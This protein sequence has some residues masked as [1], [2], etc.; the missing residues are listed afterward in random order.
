MK[1]TVAASAFKSVEVASRWFLHNG[2]TFVPLLPA[3]I[4]R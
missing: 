2:H 1:R 4:D 3:E